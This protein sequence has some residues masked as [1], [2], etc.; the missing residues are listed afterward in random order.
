MADILVISMLVFWKIFVIVAL[1]ITY[2]MRVKE[3]ILN[4]EINRLIDELNT[5]IDRLREDRLKRNK[6]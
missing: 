4:R 5:E 3:D 6:S 2:R 1:V